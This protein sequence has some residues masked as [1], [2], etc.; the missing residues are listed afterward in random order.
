MTLKKIVEALY[1][2]INT[3]ITLPFLLVIL[4]V[5]GVSVFVVTRLVAGNIQERLDNQL[6]NSSQ[7][8]TDTITDIEDTYLAALRLMAFTEGVETAITENNAERLDVLLRGLTRNENL[9]DL[10]VF[11]RQGEAILRI[12]NGPATSSFS[13]E[14]PLTWTWDSVQAVLNNTQDDLGDK[15]LEVTTRQREIGTGTG[16]IFYIVV[17]VT[18]ADDTV[19]G[20]LAGGITADTLIRR[21]RNQTLADITLY[22]P[23]G[24][25]LDSSFT[26]GLETLQVVTPRIS[27]ILNSE[28]EESPL[29]EQTINETAYQ[30][31]FSDFQMRSQNIGYLSVALPVD[32]LAERVQ[33]SRNSFILLFAGLVLTVTLVGFLVGQS[34]IRPL[35]KL[36]NTSRAI[37]EGDLSRRVG[38][39]TPDEIGEL[40]ISFDDMTDQLVKR[41]QQVS[42]LY[43]KQVEE[44]ARRDAV[45]EGISDAIIV[46][47]ADNQI[48]LLNEAAENLLRTIQQHQ[49]N[50]MAQKFNQMRLN[51]QAFYKPV[52]VQM[53]E[54]SFSV[55]TTDIR[56]ESGELRGYVLVLRDITELLATERLKDQMILQLSHELRTPLTAVRGYVEL[57]KMM[58]DAALDDSLTDY[59][60]KSLYQIDLLG[61]MVN[62]VVNVST[63]LANRLELDI[64]TIDILDV[65]SDLIDDHRDAIAAADIKLLIDLPEKTIWI[66]ADADRLKQAIGHILQNAYYYTLPGGWVKISASKAESGQLHVMIQDSGVGIAE[67]EQAKVFNRM[68]RGRSADAGPTDKRG[69]GLG[70]YIAR[71]II[72]AHEGTVYLQSEVDTGTVVTL[73]LPPRNQTKQPT[74]EEPI[75]TDNP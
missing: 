62:Q 71:E 64:E 50:N 73:E 61:G 30:L 43:H 65:L 41:N 57:V 23:D 5:A 17:P 37:R 56:L 38:L 15:F 58:G 72:E 16:T 4:I 8:A 63:M 75:H 54:Q 2:D 22:F 59:L 9:D 19:I 35:F 51:P 74:L 42:K 34:I 13:D 7:V 68:Y 45:L 47:N 1:P 31:L 53:Q 12:Y 27:S 28:T 21:L 70:L 44:T 36:V 24:R 33:E 6:V 3:R 20:G 26:A 39:R 49:D 10:I 66:E 18:Q 67:D 11:N 32:F 40:S 25:V 14:L 69:L 52:T 29:S 55:L 46:L 48:I 60:D